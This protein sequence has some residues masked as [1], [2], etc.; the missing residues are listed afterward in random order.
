[1]IT[2]ANS[3]S[4]EETYRVGEKIGSALKGREIILLSGELGAGKTLLTKGIAAAIG[5][6]PGEIVSPTFTIMNCFEGKYFLYHIDLYRLGEN[7]KRM[8]DGLPEIDDNIDEGVIVIEWAQ[9]L[10]GLY[11][12]LK[13]SVKVDIKVIEENTREISV[14]PGR[15]FY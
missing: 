15:A 5:I 10:P 12:Q 4:P 6:D 11:F 13:N 8:T 2:K 7:L 3:C 14:Q 1:M 9:Y